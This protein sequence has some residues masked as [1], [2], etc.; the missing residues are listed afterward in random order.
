M[1]APPIFRTL[2]TQKGVLDFTAR[3]KKAGVSEKIIPLMV[4]AM[5]KYTIEE[6][7]DEDLRDFA[8][9]LERASEASVQ[10]KEAATNL[11][12]KVVHEPPTRFVTPGPINFPPCPLKE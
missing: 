10:L 12:L 2:K 8:G 4:L 5:M 3:A 7:T 1:S 6:A 9:Y 11:K